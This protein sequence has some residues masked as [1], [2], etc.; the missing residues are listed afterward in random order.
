[1]EFKGGD[2]RR[3]DSLQFFSEFFRYGG[4]ENRDR[5]NECKRGV[6][7]YREHHGHACVITRVWKQDCCGKGNIFNDKSASET[8]HPVV[9]ALRAKALKSHAN[10]KG[11]GPC[12]VLV[13]NIA[14]LPRNRKTAKITVGC[15]GINIGEGPQYTSTHSRF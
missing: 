7:D 2:E 8:P 14:A 11:P 9:H 13:Y 5:R 6:E 1:M 4:R 10:L 12:R 15:N 3:Y